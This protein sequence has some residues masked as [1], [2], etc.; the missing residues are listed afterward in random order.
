MKK[1]R[2]GRVG[3]G[4]W[5]TLTGVRDEPDTT[6]PA[7]PLFT[8]VGAESAPDAAGGT[9]LV[10]V[11]GAGPG[12]RVSGLPDRRIA[13]IAQ[14]QRG[15]VSRHQLAAAGI[16]GD[17]I[18]RLAGRGVLIR[19]HRGVYAVG[20]LAPIPLTRETEA[21]LAAR[22]GSLLSHHTAA[23]LRRLQAESIGD[24]LVHVLVRGN[25]TA[26]IE[27]ARVHRTRLLD[28][29]D[30]RIHERL[31]VTS[32][33]RTLLDLAEFVT[34][35]ELERA[36][37]EALV[38]RLVRRGQI[39]ELLTRARGRPGRAFLR[40]LLARQTGPTRTRSEAEERFLAVIRSAQLPEPEVNVRI[41]GYEVDFLWRAQRLVVEIDGFKFHSSRVGFERDRGKDAR[42]QAA[43]LM[44]MRVTWIQIEEESSAVIAR[45]AQTLAS[46]G[47][48]EAAQPGPRPREPRSGQPA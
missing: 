21:L 17:A 12:I 38:S 7:S 10:S 32:P 41:Q 14:T 31:P 37:D 45:L 2:L 1:R 36:L 47:S 20:H 16:G 29:Q 30:I 22:P 11:L 35:R 25:R 8:G 46:R 19:V 18:D 27:G 23:K 28:P 26:Q 34:Q 13:L 43:G 5:W 40:A 4:S 3:G 9:H 39:S 24:G 33:A 42:L 15:T 44:T 48:G 6:G